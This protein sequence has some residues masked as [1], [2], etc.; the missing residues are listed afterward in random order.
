VD[1]DSSVRK[2]TGCV[3]TERLT[4]SSE[5][6]VPWVPEG[7][8]LGVKWT[9]HETDYPTP[10]SAEVHKQLKF[11]FMLLD[12]ALMHKG[13][14]TSIILMYTEVYTLCMQGSGETTLRLL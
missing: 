4:Q 13:N 10:S 9:D 5:Q 6:C 7:L 11:A 3:W 12:M 1:W 8:S 2:V 14:F